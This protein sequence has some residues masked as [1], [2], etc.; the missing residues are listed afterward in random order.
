MLWTWFCTWWKST[1]EKTDVPLSFLFAFFPWSD[2]FLFF[3]L[4]PSL[5]LK[6]I[7][8]WVYRDEDFGMLNAEPHSVNVN[9]LKVTFLWDTVSCSLGRLQTHNGCWDVLKL[10]ILLAPFSSIRIAGVHHHTVYTVLRRN[11]GF[12]H[13]KQ[14]SNHWALY[15]PRKKAFQSSSSQPVNVLCKVKAERE[16]GTSQLSRI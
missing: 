7:T 4:W 1:E 6:P 2:Y 10:R 16:K 15:Q 9:K 12:F 8:L 3:M 11:Q 14:R 5:S 13:A